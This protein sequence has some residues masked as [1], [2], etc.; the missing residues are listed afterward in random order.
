MNERIFILRSPI[1]SRKMFRYNSKLRDKARQLRKNMTASERHLWTRLRGRQLL[2]IQFYRQRPIGNYIVDFFAPT[3]KL[4]IEVDGSQHGE[5]EQAEKDKR[6]DAYLAAIGLTVLRFNSRE[7]IKETD[8][9]VNV[10]HRA[11]ATHMNRKIPL[12]PPFMK[13]GRS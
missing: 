8:A 7:V 2:G 3:T 13:G 6:R 1:I 5:A 4:V 11:I 9:V 10:I 12:D